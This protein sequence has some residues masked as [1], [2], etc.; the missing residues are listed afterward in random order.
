MQD[1]PEPSKTKKPEEVHNVDSTSVRTASI[2]LDKV[3]DG[4]EIEGA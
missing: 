4:K 3:G 1:T 2:S